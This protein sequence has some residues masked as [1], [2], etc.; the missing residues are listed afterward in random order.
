LDKASFLGASP[1]EAP[2]APRQ[3]TE[4]TVSSLCGSVLLYEMLSR[5]V[6]GAYVSM[7]ILIACSSKACQQQVKHVSLQ[8][9][10]VSL[11]LKHVSRK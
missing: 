4:L 1:L 5:L 8:V 7:R 6:E 2:G 11:Q 9:Q 10:H 3:G